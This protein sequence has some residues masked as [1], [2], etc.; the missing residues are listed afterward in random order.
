MVRNNFRNGQRLSSPTHYGGNH[1]K[2]ASGREDRPAG[3][4]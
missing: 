3:V 1:E 4:A 2:M